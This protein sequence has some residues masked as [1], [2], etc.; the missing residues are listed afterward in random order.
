MEEE[1]NRLRGI[2]ADGLN[3]SKQLFEAVVKVQEPID[4]LAGQIQG[5]ILKDAPL[6]FASLA[7][8]A[9]ALGEDRRSLGDFIGDINS[10]RSMNTSGWLGDLDKLILDV[11]RKVNALHGG[12][13][14]LQ[15][16]AGAMDWGGPGEGAGKKKADGTAR[17]TEAGRGDS[18]TGDAGSSSTG[19]NQT[20]A[21]NAS[22]RT[23]FGASQQRGLVASAID[24]GQG[25]A[26][27]EERARILRELMANIRRLRR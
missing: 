27:V 7:E 19:W 16:G 9:K 3:W 2:T 25:G 1:I 24:L 26:T 23:G 21:T 13:E 12:I 14:E 8:F 4:T 11:T 18:G 15:Q 17:T 10:L 5:L 6:A 20:G 22:E